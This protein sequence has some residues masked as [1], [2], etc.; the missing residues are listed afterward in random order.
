MSQWKLALF[1]LL[2]EVAIK[3]L[4]RVGANLGQPWVQEIISSKS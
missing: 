3:Y 1:F 2:I 4:E